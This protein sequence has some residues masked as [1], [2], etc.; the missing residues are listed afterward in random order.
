VF[1]DNAGGRRVSGKGEQTLTTLDANLGTLDFDTLAR[2]AETAG[3]GKASAARLVAAEMVVPAFLD[4]AEKQQFEDELHDLNSRI[5][6]GADRASIVKYVVDSKAEHTWIQL[7]R[8][9]DGALGGY[10]AVHIYELEIDG[11]LTA[12]VRCQTGTL[13]RYRG[14]NL[15]AGFFAERLLRYLVAHPLRPLYLLG[16]AV[17]PS[18]YGQLVRYADEVWPREGVETP[19]EILG[20]MDKLGDVFGFERVD[21]ENALVRNG[22]WRTIDSGGDRAY[23]ERCDR[24]GVQ[25]FLRENP[26]YVE[27]HGLL[28]LAPFTLGAVT[29][30]LARYMRAKSARRARKLVARARAGIAA[31]LLAPAAAAAT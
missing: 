15:M 27:G 3:T 13:R 19:A 1:A 6:R 10:V 31:L 20:L 12:I 9:E 11:K 25:F 18:S 23:W 8:G 4:L 24:P 16:I 21:P 22:G 30:G 29:R 26:G 17:H 14:A 5:F 2:G 7:Y 28:T